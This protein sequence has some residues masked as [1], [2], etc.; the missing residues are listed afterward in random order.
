MEKQWVLHEFPEIFPW[1]CCERGWRK[2]CLPVSIHDSPCVSLSFECP[3]PKESERNVSDWCDM[4]LLLHNSISKRTVSEY[5]RQLV[6][7]LPLKLSPQFA[8]HIQDPWILYSNRSHEA[9]IVQLR[10]DIR[11]SVRYKRSSSL[12]YHLKLA[13]PA[14]GPIKCSMSPHVSFHKLV[15]SI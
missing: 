7:G 2:Q 14:W 11:M 8:V 13:M 5:N 4:D 12:D 10:G 9:L 1:V 6:R 15:I 3:G